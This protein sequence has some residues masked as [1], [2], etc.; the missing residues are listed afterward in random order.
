SAMAQWRLPMSM[1]VL[2]SV[3]AEMPAALPPRQGAGGDRQRAQQQRFAMH[4]HPQRGRVPMRA[5]AEGSVR[6]MLVGD[7]RGE[8]VGA[9][10]GI[11][12]VGLLAFD[13]STPEVAIH[14]QR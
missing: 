4:V 7:R 9:V 6:R 14:Q 13:G 12:L 2:L 1:V 8:I 5:C 11:G 3:P 10:A